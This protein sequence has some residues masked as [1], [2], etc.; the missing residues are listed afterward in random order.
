MKSPYTLCV[1]PSVVA[2]QQLSKHFPTAITHATI[3]ELL[4]ASFF[5]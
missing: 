5:V 1:S 2:R 3:E 4:D